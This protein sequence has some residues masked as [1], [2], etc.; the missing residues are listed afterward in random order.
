VLVFGKFRVTVPAP[1]FVTAPLPAIGAVENVMLPA[2]SKTNGKFPVVSFLRKKGV[3]VVLGSSPEV[4][5]EGTDLIVYSGAWVTL[6]PELLLY[7]KTLGVPV[8][9][10]PEML[11]II[12]KNTR[13]IAIAGSH[14]K[15]TTTA[16][17][18]HVLIEAKR[19]PTVIVGSVMKELGS[20]FRAGKSDLLV[21]EADEYRRAFLN[22][23]P[24]I[25][26]IT[27]IDLDQLGLQI[28][29]LCQKILQ[30]LSF[31]HH[32]KQ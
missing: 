29:F 25:L 2:P 17:V 21:I 20:N 4:I 6:G 22:L 3:R 19:D 16:M 27:N 30:F 8:L 26:V 11:S 13:T 32:L 31:L 10:Y 15:T 5:P 7:A 14:G 12:S 28:H 18:A 9:S 24:E 23:T 1:F